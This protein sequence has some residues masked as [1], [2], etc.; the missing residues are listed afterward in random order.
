MFSVSTATEIQA[1]RV[2]YSA[3]K[4]KQINGLLSSNGSAKASR[5]NATAKS[6]SSVLTRAT[7]TRS[8]LAKTICE[9]CACAPTPED[10]EGFGR[11]LKGCLADVGVSPVMVTLCGATCAFG[12]VPLC[13]ICV[14]VSVAVLEACVLGCAAYPGPSTVMDAARNKPVR[15]LLQAK[16]TRLPA[17]GVVYRP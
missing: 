11:C 13:A 5:T 15:K 4:A 17:K 14:G 12:A 3:P 8:N 7:K 16:L 9:R 2:N 10:L 6:R 1:K